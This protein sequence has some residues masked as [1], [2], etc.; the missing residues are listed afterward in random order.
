MR[1]TIVGSLAAIALLTPVTAPANASSQDVPEACLAVNPAVPSCTFTVQSEDS[2]TG[3]TGVSAVGDWVVTV[4]RGKKKYVFKSTGAIPDGPA[5]K[6][7][8]GD[9]VT[10]YAK[11]PGTYVL[12]GHT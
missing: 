10:A 9:V 8:I 11:S 6:F 7:K 3:T 2:L 1:K 4:K 5:F 12:V